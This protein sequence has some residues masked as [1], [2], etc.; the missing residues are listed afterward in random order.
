LNGADLNKA[1]KGGSVEQRNL[2]HS[3]LRVSAVGLGG[4]NFGG[5][6]DAEQVREVVA[7]ALDLGVTFF[8]TADTYGKRG[9]GQA[10]AS[11]SAL[12][13]ALGARRKNVVVATKFGHAVD[14]EQR[15]KGAS[16]R[17]VML[18]V[19]ASLRR[20]NTDWIDLY[21]LHAPDPATPIEETLRAL[22]DLIAA[23]KVRYIGCSNTPA[24]RMADAAGAA[25]AYG[26]SAFISCQDEYSLLNR[27]A[28]KSIIPCAKQF[29][30]GLLPFY[31]LASGLLTGKYR[32]GESPPPGS[33]F[34]KPERFEQRF[35][36]EA[37]MQRLAALRG[38]A[39]AR[40]RS[41]LELAMSWLV[42]QK[43]VGSVM[44]GAVSPDQARANI[45]AADWRLSREELDE[46]DRLCATSVPSERAG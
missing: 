40:G 35:Q 30:M 37:T 3:G 36:N 25:R 26:L 38:F 7:C 4:N 8:D 24:W 19:E 45:A 43:A 34:A 46:I 16:R 28:E 33:R 1:R 21:Q 23:G 2:G 41:L 31:P 29:G 44:A 9:G 42:A 22:E 17:Y 27:S 20:L 10:G 6:I 18:A 39:Q 32:P 5:R 13:A 12:G 11:E 15:L 14:A